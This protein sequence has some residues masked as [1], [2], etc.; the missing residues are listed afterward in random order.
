[1]V[2]LWYLLEILSLL[3]LLSLK[4]LWLYQLKDDS[5][6]WYKFGWLNLFSIQESPFI[7][8]MS[9]MFLI[10]LHLFMFYS[11]QH[12]YHCYL[13]KVTF[14]PLLEII[15][16]ILMTNWSLRIQAVSK[17]CFF[18]NLAIFCLFWLWIQTGF[19]LTEICLPLP[20]KTGIKSM[21][22]LAQTFSSRLCYFSQFYQI[23]FFKEK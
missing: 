6:S 20:S 3:L 9:F 18:F 2:I 22:Y 8:C 13:L 1:M 15:C 17:M 23:T 19:E 4:F 16:L 12:N 7:F 21:W 14:K 10:F 5:L 11:L